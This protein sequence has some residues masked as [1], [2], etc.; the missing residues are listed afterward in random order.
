MAG[1]IGDSTIPISTRKAAIKTIRT[2]NEKYASPENVSG[3]WDDNTIIK[4]Y[5]GTPEQLAKYKA[6][7]GRK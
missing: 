4:Q 5:G 6:M 7:K 2:L 1:Q 3:A